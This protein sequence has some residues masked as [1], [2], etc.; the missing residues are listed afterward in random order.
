[1][2]SPTPEFSIGIDDKLPQRK[3]MQDEVNSVTIRERESNDQTRVNVEKV[4]AL[5]NFDAQIKVFGYVDLCTIYFF[6]PKSLIG[7]SLEAVKQCDP[8]RMSDRDY[9]LNSRADMKV[10]KESNF[11]ICSSEEIEIAHSGQYLF[12]ITVDESKLGNPATSAAQNLQGHIDYG[13]SHA[14]I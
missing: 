1:I 5:V 2:Q 4:A 11:L 3:R 10:M 14:V 6:R 13:W 9:Q 12:S 8:L 7:N